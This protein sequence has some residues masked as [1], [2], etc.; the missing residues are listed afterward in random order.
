MQCT[1]NL[2]FGVARPLFS[3]EVITCSLT[4]PDHFLAQGIK[5]KCYKVV[6]LHETRFE[7]TTKKQSA[8][9]VLVLEA[10]SFAF[11][12]IAVAFGGFNGCTDLLKGPLG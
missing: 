1:W 11:Q 6:W 5:Y 4:W 3:G 10:R 12:T 8:A 7:G 9:H 2:S